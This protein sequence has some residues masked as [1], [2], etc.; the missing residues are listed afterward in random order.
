MARVTKV[1]DAPEKMS[2]AEVKRRNAEYAKKQQELFAKATEA[3]RYLD[4]TKTES[5]TF[6]AFSKETL[7]G[8]M[9]NPKSNEANLRNLS[10]FLYRMSQ[11]YRRLIHHNAQQMDLSAV[12]V[13]P[14]I[15]ITQENDKETVLKD[16]YETCLLLE[17][18][19][20]ADEI[21]KMLVIAWR[22]D[23]AYGFIYA[24]DDDFMIM[25]L[26]GDYCKVSSA[27]FDGTLNFAFDFSYFRSH[28]ECL[29]FW[30][31]DF[32]KLYN[33]FLNDNNLRWQELPPEKTICLKV[34]ID[35]P[36]MSLPPYLPMFEAIIDNVDLQSI[37]SVKDNLAIYKLLVARLK[38]LDGTDVADDFEVNIDTAIKYYN[39]LS[40]ALPDEVSIV[41]SPLP[42]DTIEFEETSTDDNDMISNSTNNLF[43]TSGGSL[44]LN[45]LG[46]TATV[47][48][49]QII[50]D[51]LQGLR[52]LLGEV[53][54]WTN[55]YLRYNLSNP[56]IVRYI[57][58]SPWLRSEKR[59]E[60]IESCQYGVPDKMLLAALD[61]MSPLEILR[62][63][64]LE[65]DVLDIT[66]K[67]VPL[68]SSYTQ[69]STG[70]G[71][72][73]K[74]ISDLTDEGERT[75]DKDY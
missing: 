10:R 36:T 29:E 14:R 65:N 30:D 67:W 9:R 1:S 33:K 7:R 47:V 51:M 24:D 55:R 54:A 46:T 74:D 21:Y 20:L 4:L 26:D 75:R 60:V 57:E 69:S 59:K 32:K 43:K 56:S 6:T 28:S 15:D 40:E 72:Q 5:R 2:V 62:L 27:N 34:N 35:D 71:G 37:M 39:K 13:S 41:L 49:A 31:P 44:V 19:N 53:E 58:V 61:G 48:R 73:E 70:S 50:A 45:N 18:M 12:T 63:Q 42:I 16:Y 8:Y 64:F 68:Q 3:L 52:P 11:P 17:K 66:N 23:T 38:P 22:E 25:P